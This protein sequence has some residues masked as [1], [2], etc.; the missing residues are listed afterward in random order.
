MQRNDGF[1][2]LDD[3]LNIPED[4]MD[5]F[6]NNIMQLHRMLSLNGD[7][8]IV[9][10]NE[11]KIVFRFYYDGKYYYF[12]YVP[13]NMLF[14]ELIY[15]E[16]CKCLK[17]EVTSYDIASIGNY[18]GVIS[19][20][21][22]KEGVN[23]I[24]GG[25][26]LESAGFKSDDEEN[27]LKFNTIEYIHK[28]LY[29]RYKNS[30]YY[31]ECLKVVMS[32]LVNMLLADILTYQVDR[33]YKNWQIVEYKDEKFD[34]VPPFDNGMLTDF[35][36][37]FACFALAIHNQINGTIHEKQLIEDFSTTYGKEV[38]EESLWVIGQDNLEKIVARIEEKIG[39]KVDESIKEN[40]R[41]RFMKIY[42]HLEN[43]LELDMT[44]KLE[45]RSEFIEL[46]PLLKRKAKA[47]GEAIAVSVITPRDKIHA[48]HHNDYIEFHQDIML[49]AL[50]KLYNIG[51]SNDV[52]DSKL[53][54][55]L[56]QIFKDGDDFLLCSYV[57]RRGL[58]VFIN[59]PAF[60]TKNELDELS[61]LNETFKEIAPLINI[62][63]SCY[64]PRTKD[65][66]TKLAEF[67]LQD[68]KIRFNPIERTIDFLINNNRIV[69]Y[70]VSFPS[71]SKSPLEKRFLIQ[72]KQ[73]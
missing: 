8:A 27:A 46:W 58:E 26:L 29:K 65:F 21:F 33:H 35:H 60:I 12:K 48:L 43:L 45:E 18:K 4:K 9:K 1:I 59:I 55:D 49:L 63:V 17:I 3:I 68:Q 5:I 36:P 61:K 28:A 47:Y 31:K 6:P 10:W 56:E 41:E 16:I 44:S 30:P 32:K 20:D 22:R 15:E 51:S 11:P 66:N 64:D 69:D 23:Y 70:D 67:T 14:N 42:N 62:K 25:I 71:L 57:K 13:Y 7:V 72:K 40:Y 2:V 54:E 73:E 38:L 39:C 34:L 52:V 24:D 53:L 37:T 19:Q 50:K